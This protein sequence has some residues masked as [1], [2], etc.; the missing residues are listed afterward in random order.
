MQIA[1][2]TGAY[3]DLYSKVPPLLARTEAGTCYQKMNQD[4]MLS[5]RVSFARL[6]HSWTHLG[7]DRLLSIQT[8]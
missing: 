3:F 7:I 6:G 8:D 2:V 4:L 1:T 5:T